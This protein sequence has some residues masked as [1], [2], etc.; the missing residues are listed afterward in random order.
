MMYS[1]EAK[2]IGIIGY[3]VRYGKDIIFSYCL[4]NILSKGG[5]DTA[6]EYYQLRRR[7]DI[8]TY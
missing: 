1:Y 5:F 8:E 7:L 4:V 2:N 6:G 3:L